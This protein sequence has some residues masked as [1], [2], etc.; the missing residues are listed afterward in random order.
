MPTFFIHHVPV[1][2]LNQTLDDTRWLKQAHLETPDVAHLKRIRKDSDTG[3]AT[4]LLSLVDD[5]EN[6]A[7]PPLPPTLSLPSPRIIPVP[8]SVALTWPSLELKNDLWPTVYAPKRKDE[9]EPWTR[10]QA[11]WA[12]NA[13]QTVADAAKAGRSADEVNHIIMQLRIMGYLQ[14]L[15]CRLPRSSQ[16]PTKTSLTPPRSWPP[17]LVN[18]PTTLSA[19]QP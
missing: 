5:P 8:A 3:L 17:T 7:P 6:P 2:S 4:L 9:V 19:T 11:A 13:M 14:Q 16:H 12:W 18:Q 10:G 15:S 1:Q